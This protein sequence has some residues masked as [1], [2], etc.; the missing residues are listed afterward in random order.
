M[1]RR[2]RGRGSKTGSRPEAVTSDPG[3]FAELVDAIGGIERIE[4]KLVVAKP[5]RHAS[6]R[7]ALASGRGK[8]SART[9]STAAPAVAANRVSRAELRRLRAGKIRPQAS[10]DLHNSNRREAHA[11]LCHA[12]SRIAEA[13]KRSLLV[14][15]GKGH[16]S[17][18]GEAVLKR[19]LAEWLQQPPLRDRV[20][21]SA[22]ALPRDGGLGAT[23]LLVR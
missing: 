8:P 4:S 3:S 17:P 1:S 19:S 9:N 16:R 15:H 11:R 22:P 21:A 12:V 7:P 20:I 18:G 6:K 10:V 2:S 23:Y 5:P 14:I 13:G